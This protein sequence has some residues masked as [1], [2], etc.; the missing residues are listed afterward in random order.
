MQGPVGVVLLLLKAIG[1]GVFCVLGMWIAI[2]MTYTWKLS[3]A[4]AKQGLTGVGAV[5]GGWAYLL[6]SPGVVAL[7]TIAFGAG[8]YLAVRL[9]LR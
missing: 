5:A 4:N 1:G 8:F 7:V 6:Q 9:S 2:V 3:S